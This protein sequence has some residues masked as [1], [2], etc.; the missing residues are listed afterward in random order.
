MSSVFA[1]RDPLASAVD[2]CGWDVSENLDPDS[3]DPLGKTSKL[4]DSLPSL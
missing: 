1:Q 3:L 4:L 2:A